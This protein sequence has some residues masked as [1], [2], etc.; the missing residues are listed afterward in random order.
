M[1]TIGDGRVL[2]VPS[3]VSWGN[4]L[5]L[6]QEMGNQYQP[7]GKAEQNRCSSENDPVRSL[8]L[9]FYTPEDGHSL[10]GCFHGSEVQVS[11]QERLGSERRVYGLMYGDCPGMAISVPPARHQYSH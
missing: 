5:S 11:G 2:G 9:G 3:V 6:V 1:N 4:R 10:E 8:A 7:A